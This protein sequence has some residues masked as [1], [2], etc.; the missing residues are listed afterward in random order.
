MNKTTIIAMGIIASALF[1]SAAKPTPAEALKAIQPTGT[2]IDV[3]VL[4]SVVPHGKGSEPV[5]F[6]GDSMMRILGAQA[7]KEFKKAG[8]ESVLSFS[9]LGSGLVRKSVFDWTAK[10]DELVKQQKP[11]MVFIA[12]GTNDRQA[13]ET[14]DGV[15]NYADSSRWTE[16]YSKLVGGVM[17]QFIAAGL[18]TIVW[19]L[20]PDMKDAAH[21]EHA[22]LLVG[23]VT[24]EAIKDGR[25]D[26]VQLFD[27]ASILS[28]K[29]GKYSQFKMSPTGEALSVRDPDGVH[30]GVAGGR[31]VAK[32][33]LKIYWDK[34]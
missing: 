19:L 9:S 8:V 23:I 10:I 29:P 6:I 28:T 26:K 16:E 22:K 12:L 27:M 34:K 15:V 17:D 4:E 18:D 1:A 25:K 2:D 11:K 31:L 7:E 21:Q 30:L 33:L 20:P 24:T 3:K 13:L 14:E 5:L 32:E